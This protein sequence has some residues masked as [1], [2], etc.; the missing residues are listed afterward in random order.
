MFMNGPLRR[1]RTTLVGPQSP[2]LAWAGSAQTTDTAPVVG[3]DGTIYIATI[4]PSPPRLM[5]VNP[6]GTTKWTR[7]LTSDLEQTPAIML[8]GRI[9]F[10]DHFGIVHVVNED[11]T[12][13]WSY[14]SGITCAC[15]QMS[16][17]IGWD[18]AIYAP[19]DQTL[20][21]FEPDGNIRWTFDSPRGFFGPPAILPDGTVYVTAGQLFALDATGS[22]IW[23]FTPPGPYASLYGAPAVGYD[24]TIYA[25]SNTPNPVA[26]NPDGTLKWQYRLGSCCAPPIT[27]SPAVARDGTVYFPENVPG[28]SD[29][30]AGLILALNPDASLRWKVSIDGTPSSPSIGGDGTIYVAGGHNYP[31]TIYALNPGG[32]PKWRFVESNGYLPSTPAIAGGR[33]YG[34]DGDGIYAIG[35]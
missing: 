4:Y 11:G 35:P 30:N 29:G 1:G 28:P 22:L 14:E 31:F 19:I 8:D 23:E 34:S 9:V 13:S 10:T 3:R 25:N 6:D 33:L 17:G 27:A 26:V 16:L 20:F 24:G 5:A 15:P 32:T 21:V 12:P 7:D 18:G 2:H